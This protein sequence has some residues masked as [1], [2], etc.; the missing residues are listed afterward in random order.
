MEIIGNRSSSNFP[1]SFWR[2]SHRIQEELS[3]VVNA[4]W[5]FL[6]LNLLT[7]IMRK[8]IVS[9]SGIRAQ[10]LKTF[11]I[12]CLAVKCFLSWNSLEIKQRVT[13]KRIYAMWSDWVKSSHLMSFLQTS[14]ELQPTPDFMWILLLP[15]QNGIRKSWQST[16]GWWWNID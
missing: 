2:K 11:F 9:L 4:S 12:D 13:Q 7:H 15:D 8:L 6:S 16:G 14:F 3:G 10:V 1:G 5:E